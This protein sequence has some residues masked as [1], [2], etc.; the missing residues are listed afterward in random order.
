MPI[1]LNGFLQGDLIGL[2]IFADEDETMQSLA[3]KLQRAASV[4]V[5]SQQ[6]GR[7][8]VLLRGRVLEPTLTVA[9]AGFEP[10]DRFDVVVGDL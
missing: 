2:V 7:V 4:R 9:R 5:R 1:P 6:G 10:L 8:Q 3:R